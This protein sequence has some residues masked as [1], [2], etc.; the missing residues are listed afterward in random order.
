MPRIARA[1]HS[2]APAKPLRAFLAPPS[3]TLPSCF[4]TLA[5]VILLNVCEIDLP[6]PPV[7]A[8]RLIDTSMFLRPQKISTKYASVTHEEMQYTLTE[9]FYKG[10]IHG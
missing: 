3:T 1:L 8:S 6:L 7:I 5:G 10:A 9:C 2:A 4:Y